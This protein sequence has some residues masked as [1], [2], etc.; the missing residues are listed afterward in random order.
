MGSESKAIGGDLL[1]DQ[2]KFG[3]SAKESRRIMLN[4]WIACFAISQDCHRGL[5]PEAVPVL[6]TC[7]RPVEELRPWQIPSWGHVVSSARPRVSN[8]HMAIEAGGRLRWT[9]NSTIKRRHVRQKIRD[10]D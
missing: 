3:L 4:H 7:R 1:A 5:I 9:A 8:V 10:D 6:L 2:M